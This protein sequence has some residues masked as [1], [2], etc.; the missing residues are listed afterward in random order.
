M[1][2]FSEIANFYGFWILNKK[3]KQKFYYNIKHVK[4]R[5]I[6]YSFQDSFC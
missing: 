3:F 5:E 2:N 1:V 6:S 4:V